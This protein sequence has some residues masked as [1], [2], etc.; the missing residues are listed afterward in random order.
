MKSKVA[1]VT[2]GTSGIGLAAARG[3][4][5]EGAVVVLTSRNEKRAQTALETFEK[6]ASVSWIGSD[7]SDGKSVARLIDTILEHH[8]RLD[9]AFNNGGSIGGEDIAPIAE[10]SEES[11][12]RTI[13]GY[14]TSVFLCMRYQLPPMLAAKRGVVVNMSSIY[15]LRGHSIPGG[16][17]YAAA[18]HGVL[19]L[20]NSAA[21]QY[22]S[23][24][25]RITAITPGWVETPPIAEWMKADPG[26]AAT[27]TGLTPRGRVASPDEVAN[28]VLFL[29]SDA[30]SAMIGSP[31]VVD[32]G[33]LS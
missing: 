28:A 13:D 8:G 9:Y 23:S 11:W 33:F 15:G 4:A 5:R 25:V 27:I 19:G 29:C 24:G 22:G 26:F 10:M 2:G 16:G 30:A 3:F 6:G 1:L 31:L 12:R 14:L 17:A 7:T 32:G 21:R 18:K 20:T